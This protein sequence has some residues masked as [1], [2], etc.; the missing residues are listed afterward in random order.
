M[1]NLLAEGRI[2]PKVASET[3]AKIEI[4]ETRLKTSKGQ[5]D[6]ESKTHSR[7]PEKLKIFTNC[8]IDDHM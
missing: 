8:S 4:P 6:G 5:C 1:I 7:N 3:T 2:K